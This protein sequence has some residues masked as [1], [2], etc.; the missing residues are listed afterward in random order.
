LPKAT[1]YTI[2]NYKPKLFE[3]SPT[4]LSFRAPCLQPVFPS[5]RRH[6]VTKRFWPSAWHQWHSGG[7]GLEWGNQRWGSPG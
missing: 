2:I 3:F 4:Y 6:Q 7:V 5:A 1:K